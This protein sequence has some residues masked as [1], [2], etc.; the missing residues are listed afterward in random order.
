MAPRERFGVAIL[1]NLDRVGLNYALRS[2]LMDACFGF[3]VTDWSEKVRLDLKNNAQRL[4]REAEEKF[5][6]GRNQRTIPSH[7]IDMYV[8][9]YTS[10]L[11]GD[12]HI[13]NERDVLRL[14]LGSR[15]HGHM[16][17]WSDESFRVKFEEPLHEDWL[18]TF[19]STN[20]TI[21]GLS[22]QEAPWLP[23]WYEEVEDL[24]GFERG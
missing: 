11:Y 6:A 14:Q 16:T 17:H 2:W 23:D 22:A 13:T 8:G 4:L 12:I 3:P 24:G 9:T 7:P 15:F 10:P 19:A 21:T 5:A 20:R 1:T 18:V